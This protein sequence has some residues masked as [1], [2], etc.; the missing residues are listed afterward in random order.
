VA[1]GGVEQALRRIDR[2]EFAGR[3]RLTPRPCRRRP[4]SAR[5]ISHIDTSITLRA[6]RSRDRNRARFDAGH[7]C[8]KAPSQTAP[9]RGSQAFR[10]GERKAPENPTLPFEKSFAVPGRVDVDARRTVS[11]T[12]EPLA[13]EHPGPLAGSSKFPRYCAPPTSARPRRARQARC[14]LDQQKHCALV[15]DVLAPPL[16]AAIR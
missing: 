6:A 14:G 13:I 7:R 1:A 3:L 12:P 4:R 2:G 11:P 9:L 16:K 8:A 10:R 15:L 5:G